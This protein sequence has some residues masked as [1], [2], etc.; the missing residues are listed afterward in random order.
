MPTAATHRLLGHQRS[1]AEPPRLH[2]YLNR[3]IEGFLRRF[4]DSQNAC[5]R[6][7]PCHTQDSGHS[8]TDGRSSTLA[9]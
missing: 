3:C 5:E 8:S 1:L 7:Y 2:L 9:G 6:T 4:E